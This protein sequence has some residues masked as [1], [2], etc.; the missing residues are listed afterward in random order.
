[1]SWKD[2]S[3][4][5]GV[6][7]RTLERRQNIFNIDRTGSCSTYTTISVERLSSVLREVWEILPDAGEIYII[8]ACCQRNSFVQR[9]RIRHAINTIDPVNRVL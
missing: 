2:V 8:G 7:V 4:D 9:E 5:F 3:L 6:S 1:M